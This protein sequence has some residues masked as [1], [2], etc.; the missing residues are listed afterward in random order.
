MILAYMIS[1]TVLVLTAGRL[2]DLFGRKTAFV[3]A[4][5]VFGLASLGAGFAADGTQLILWRIVQGIGGAFIFANG[6]ALVTDA[7]PS[8]QLGLAM[9]TNTMVAAIGLVIGPVL[10]GALVAISWHWVFWFNVPLALAGGLWARPG[11]PRALLPATRSAASTSRHP[12]LRPR[13]HRARLRDLARR[14]L[15]LGRPVVIGAWPSPR[16]LLP[17]FVLIEHRGT[18][19]MLDLSI[20]RNRLFAAATGAAFINGLSRF[21]LLFIFVFYY[22]GAQGDDPITAGIKLAPMAIGM[23]VASPLAGIWADRHGS[24]AL[25]AAGMLVTAL[26]LAA[27]DD[28][29]GR[30]PLL[31]GHALAGPGRDRLGD[32]QLAQH[33]GD[34]GHGAGRAARIAAGARTMLQNTGAVISIAFVLA[35]VTAAVPKESSSRSSPA[36]PGSDRAPSSSRSST[37]CTRRSGCSPR[38]RSSGPG[39]AAAAAARRARAGGAGRAVERGRAEEPEGDAWAPRAAADRRGREARR[40]HAAD[41]PLLRGDRP[42]ARRRRARAGAHRTYAERRRAPHRAAAPEGP[43]RRLARGAEGA[44]RAEGA[45]PP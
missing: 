41:D 32:V 11:P 18:A 38:P 22:Q 15:R 3:G 9:G 24:R 7:F 25:A 45:R 30:Q 27:D 2:S 26:G 29:A 13:P 5:V 42:A 21:A 43:A 23:L 8:E 35:I 6:P 10:G 39:L 1:S 40:H 12:H 31:G 20:F 4:F 33:R 36:S 28:A 16:V 34:D 14:H 37:T 44:G 17:L 19:P